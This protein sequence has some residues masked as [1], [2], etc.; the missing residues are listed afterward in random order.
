LRYGGVT[1]AESLGYTAVELNQ[2]L[3]AKAA[4]PCESK[5]LTSTIL[6]KRPI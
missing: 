3:G 4:E 1:S 2:L 6:I 5:S